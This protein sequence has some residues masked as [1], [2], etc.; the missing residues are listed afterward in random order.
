MI[1]ELREFKALV[2]GPK[3]PP[4]GVPRPTEEE[5]TRC[6]QVMLARQCIYPDMQTIGPSYRILA[7]PDYQ[8]FFRKF[9]AAMDLEI[10]HDPRTGMVA[11]RVPGRPRYDWQSARLTKEETA[12]LAALSVTY[13]EGHKARNVD[14][15][16]RFETTT[17]EVFDKVNGI[18]GIE[19]RESRF[20]E[21]LED[22]QRKGIVR[23]EGR[24]PVDRVWQLT[25]LQGVDVAVP[26]AYRERMT[27][28]CE[29]RELPPPPDAAAAPDGT[30]TEPA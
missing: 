11:L 24:D 29:N 25:I 26:E 18:A 6:I 9:F 14:Q 5:V 1:D 17:N 30:A 20:V 19:I 15:H 4:G 2:D 8:D 28:W 21:I 22:F 7:A 12:V 27:A 23:V 13:E 3:A 16:G 10:H